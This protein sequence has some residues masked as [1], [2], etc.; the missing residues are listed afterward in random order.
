MKK[1]IHLLLVAILAGLI[2]TSC[3][4]EDSNVPEACFVASEERKTGIPIDFSTSCT[5]NASSYHWDFGDSKTSTDGYPSH[6]Y[7][8]GGDYAV[9]LTVANT[10]GDT[11][12][13]THVMVVEAP[14]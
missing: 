4:K 9:T 11:D 6:T 3:A 10:N 8:K 13:V 2:L 12:D 1:Q 14:V 5:L 7:N